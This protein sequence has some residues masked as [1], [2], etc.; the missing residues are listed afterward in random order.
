MRVN[1]QTITVFDIAVD[2][3][4]KDI[5]NIHF[6]VYPPEGRVRVSVPRHITDE[7]IRLVVGSRLSWIKSKQEALRNKPRP[8]ERHYV[9]GESHYFQGQRYRLEVVEGQGKHTISL[10]HG[11][12]MLLHVSPGT[13][14]EKR[15]L[16]LD[17]WYRQQLNRIIPDLIGKWQPIIGKQVQSWGIKR[18]KTRW[19][20]CNINERR[21][22][23]NLELAKK[24]PEC[25]EYV[26]VHELVHL[27]E[28]YHNANFK[29]LMSYY[30][31]QWRLCQDM[32][33]NM[34]AG[35]ED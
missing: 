10:E 5:R 19:G 32:L 35:H 8:V 20:S 28:R 14:K 2:I 34:A 3:V 1:N 6:R 9:S 33:N 4:R 24:P 25:L 23:L 11:A 13:T 16:V 22:W 29:R 18:M 27:L 7:D 17:S 30:L 21:I 12:R 15:S 31:P 26:L